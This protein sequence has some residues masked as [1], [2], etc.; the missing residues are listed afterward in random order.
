MSDAHEHTP[1]EPAADGLSGWEHSHSFGQEVRRPGERR[2]LLVIAITATMMVV[3]I[4]AGVAFGSMALLADGLHMGS[5]TVALGIAAFAYIYARRH[6]HDLRYSFGVGKVNALGG[7]TGAVLLASFA[8]V[9]AA[10]S[11]DRFIN[12]ATIDY[13]YAI[14]V[15]VVGLLVNGVCVLLLDVGHHDHGGAGAHEHDH[16]LRAAYLHVLADALTSLLAIVA[17]LAAKYLGL[18]WM[19]PLMGIVGAVLVGRWSLGLMRDSGR[20][21][22]DRQAPEELRRRVVGA[23]EGGGDI[24]DGGDS[25]GGAADD[26]RVT[27]L[28]LWAIAP[29]VYAAELVI[30]S[31]TPLAPDAYKQRLPRSLGLGHVAVEVHRPE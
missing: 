19:D 28:H 3:E 25:G 11:V 2:T 14:L 22:L 12:P 6:A 20:V 7:F 21:L 1:A 17:L 8:V 24:L 5:H 13:D 9:M 27:D 30:V 18:A 15:A 29:G 16:N 26:T 31:S 10:G 23:V 4:V